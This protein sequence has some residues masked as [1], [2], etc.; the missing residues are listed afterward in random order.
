MIYTFLISVVFIAEII[1][2]LTVLINL[3]KLDKAVLKFDETVCLFNSKI[4]DIGALIK[5]ISSQ[6][7]EIIESELKNIFKLFLLGT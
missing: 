1:I 4:K 7:Y 6:V 2:A 5:G 3:I